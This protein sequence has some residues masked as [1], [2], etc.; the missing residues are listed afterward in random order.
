MY[1][2]INVWISFKSLI[3]MNFRAICLKNRFPKIIWEENIEQFL[4]RKYQM[5]HN[6]W[7]YDI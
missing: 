6:E 1:S 4:R 7:G 3:F 5:K 2:L